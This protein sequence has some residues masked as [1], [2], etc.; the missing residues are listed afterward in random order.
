MRKKK[1]EG[2]KQLKKLKD[3]S[4]ATVLKVSKYKIKNIEQEGRVGWFVFEVDDEAEN[5]LREFINGDLIGN[6]KDF[7]DAK[8]TLKQMLFSNV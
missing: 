6:L 5:R 4:Y 3:L 1:I 7:D 2:E 8:K